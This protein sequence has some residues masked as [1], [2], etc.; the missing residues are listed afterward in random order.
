[1]PFCAARRI[2]KNGAEQTATNG[3]GYET[4]SNNAEPMRTIVAPSS[5]AIS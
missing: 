3:R 5:V 2:G 1:M 4:P